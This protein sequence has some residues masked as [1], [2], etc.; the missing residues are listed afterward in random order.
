MTGTVLDHF[1]DDCAIIWDDDPES[2]E[3]WDGRDMRYR[4]DRG[5]MNLVPPPKERRIRVPD[6]EIFC[7]VCGKPRQL[8]CGCPRPGA[9]KPEEKFHRPL[10]E[11]PGHDMMDISIGG[12]APVR[13]GAMMA[14]KAITVAVD[15]D[16]ELEELEELEEPEQEKPAAAKKKGAVEV[17]DPNMLSSKAAATIIG[18]DGR[19]LRKYL[20][21]KHG[22]LGQGKR[23]E[24]HKDSIDELKAEFLAHGKGGG[25]KVA[26]AAKAAPADDEVPTPPAKKRKASAPKP[27]AELEEFEEITDLDDLD[28]DEE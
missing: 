9:L 18:T 13:E 28:F 10:I 17:E 27:D 12:N 23:W 2:Y 24:I 6:T 3:R 14:K 4:I 8:K 20:R 22:T 19:T 15:E 7:K 11:V 1:A 25:T 26:K 16:V 21:S 5:Q